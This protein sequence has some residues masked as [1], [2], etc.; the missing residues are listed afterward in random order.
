MIYAEVVV[1][2]KGTSTA[3]RNLTPISIRFEADIKSTIERLAKADRRSVA[4]WV[5]KYVID[6]MQDEGLLPK[7]GEAK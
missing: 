1:L 6:H 3:K 7:D 5:E 4:S 2:E